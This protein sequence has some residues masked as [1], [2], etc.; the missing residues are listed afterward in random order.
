MV[1]LNISPNI[2]FDVRF[3]L[4]DDGVDKVFGFRV[5]ALR[6]KPEDAETV[7]A[8]LE[9]AQLRMTAW[10]GEPPACPLVNENGADVPAGP[11]ALAALYANLEQMPGLVYSGYLVAVSAKARVG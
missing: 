10:L 11:E 9:R 3:T 6:A 1:R 7:G 8:F 4:N 5:S 2:A